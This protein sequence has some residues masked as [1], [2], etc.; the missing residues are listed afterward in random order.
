MKLKCTLPIILCPLK[1][2][3]FF[4]P[5]ATLKSL[6]SS[7]RYIVEEQLSYIPFCVRHRML[8]L[9]RL[10][11]EREREVIGEGSLG[12]GAVKHVNWAS[13]RIETV[14]PAE[15]KTFLISWIFPLKF[16]FIDCC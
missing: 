1:P 5:G 7:V 13:A 16:F 9:L 15:S 14:K 11:N 12:L 4:S 8:K 10:Y 6:R 3:S 2:L